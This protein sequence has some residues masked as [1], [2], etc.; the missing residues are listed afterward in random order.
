VEI[1]DG[2]AAVSGDK[3]CTMSLLFSVVNAEH[4]G[5]AHEAIDP[6]VRRPA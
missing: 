2:P 5:K 4:N 1:E 3:S 6:E